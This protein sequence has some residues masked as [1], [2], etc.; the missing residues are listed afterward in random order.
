[1]RT[2]SKN[3]AIANRVDL[4]L[5]KSFF[6]SLFF[7]GQLYEDA[8]VGILTVPDGQPM[9]LNSIEA[10]FQEPPSEDVTF[11]LHKYSGNVL[12]DIT[13]LQESDFNNEGTVTYAGGSVDITIPADHMNAK[14]K[15]A[16][17]VELTGA[18]KYFFKAPSSFTSSDTLG[19]GV[20]IILGT[21]LTTEN[22]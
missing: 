12:G 11:T 3:L 10:V 20:N 1:M 4:D 16:S 18:G 19:E 22:A 6:Y 13:Q 14:K 2:F 9:F 15:F 17:S 21:S 7:E 5:E 8:I